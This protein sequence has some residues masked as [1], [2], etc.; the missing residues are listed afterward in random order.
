MRLVL[1]NCLTRIIQRLR[2][3]YYA[4]NGYDVDKSA[5]LE[6]GVNLDRWN[7][8]GVHIGTNTIVTSH[9]TIL[10]H[11]L[12][13]VKK[14]RTYVGENVDT[15][16][17]NNCVIGIGA[18]I[19]PGIRIGDEVVV[20]AGAVVTK[21]VPSNVVVAGNPARVIRTDISMDKLRL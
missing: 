12:I 3:Y 17:G 4:F 8:K 21:D 18:I 14:T 10:S 19:L 2:Y 13:P 6:R 16:V 7:P 11:Y 15:Y 1:R 5:Q 9:V 20:G